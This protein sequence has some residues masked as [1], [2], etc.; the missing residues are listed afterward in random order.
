MKKILLLSILSL[1]TLLVSCNKEAQSGN[2]TISGK[3]EGLKQG[4]L[5]IQRIQDTT[6][7]TLDS[8]IIKG[9]SEFQTSLQ[10]EDP[11]M[12]F[13][14][15]NRGTT[16]SQDN[17]L[18]FFAEPGKIHIETSLKNFYADAKISGSKNQNVYEDYLK[19]RALITDK[20]NEILIAI[21]NAEKEG[22]LAQKDSLLNLS[23]KISGKRYL[24]AVNFAITHADSDVAS[25]IAL[26]EIYDRPIKYLDTIQNSLKDGAADRKYGKALKEFI[27]ERK[28]GEKATD[29]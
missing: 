19:T 26:S 6:M 21:L 23:T 17:Q 20:Q 24:N 14:S 28:E 2:L 12:F 1:S 29:N 7:V 16:A 13:L 22:K 27:K 11:E 10:I 3:V 8:I 15:L 5:Y 4:T 9:N 25:Y 18:M